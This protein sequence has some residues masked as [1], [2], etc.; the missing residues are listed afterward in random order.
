[1]AG[2]DQER[3]G[4]V[5]SIQRMSTEDGPGLRTT[6]F[7]K[8]CSLG[9]AWCHNPESLRARQQ[10]IWHDWKCMGCGTC[11]EVCPNEAHTHAE[12][13]V[14]VDPKRCALCGTC[15]E[16]CPTGALEMLGSRFT[17][18]ALLAEVLKDRAYFEPGGGVTLSGGEP[19]L[20]ARFVVEFAE[21]CRDAGVHV[22]LDTCGMNNPRALLDCVAVADIVLYDLK[23]RDSGEHER[24]TGQPNERI[25]ENALAVRDYMAAH[26][27]PSALWVRTPL[28]PDTTA[29][30][31]N[32]R[33]IGAFIAENLG[34]V[35]SRWEL[36]GFNNLCAEKYRRL[37]MTWQYAGQPAMG[38]DE[39]ARFEA[40]ARASGV[41]PA[42]VCANGPTRAAPLGA[43]EQR[44]AS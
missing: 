32:I 19:T 22:A 8:G 15:V 39:L 40:I 33:G 42:I 38:A 12:E 7:L 5:L 36:S 44:E 28:I 3:T 1:M 24:F 2:Q 20:Q 16:E 13:G 41:D 6:V 14:A 43:D 17:A 9:C 34:G 4:R 29:T 27:S 18:A 37:G 21:L 35:V 11:A 30:E 10:V 23:L 26:D 31:A 25:L